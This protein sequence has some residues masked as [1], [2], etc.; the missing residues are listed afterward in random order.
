M[1]V[2][3]GPRELMRQGPLAGRYPAVAAMVM[4]ALVPYLALSASLGP[5]TPIIAKSLHTSIQTLE[6]RRRPGQR[7]VRRRHGAG[8]PVRPAPSSTQDVGHLRGPARHRIG[9]DGIGRE[10]RH[11]HRGPRDPGP[12]YQLALD[13]RR[14]TSGPR[15]PA[16]QAPGHDG[17]LEHVHFRGGGIRPVHRRPAGPVE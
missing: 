7:R 8:G 14:A 11:V 1:D 17:Y 12:L 16:E 4:L 5:L 13:R 2:R 15:L 10:R 3:A 9:A 6:P